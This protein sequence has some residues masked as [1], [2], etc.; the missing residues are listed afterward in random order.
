MQTIYPRYTNTNISD[1]PGVWLAL[2][3]AQNQ[4]TQVQELWEQGETE[5]AQVLLDLVKE[6]LVKAQ[7]KVRSGRWAFPLSV[8]LVELQ[9]DEAK[10][11]LDMAAAELA[12][13]ELELDKAIIVAPFDGIVSD[14]II[15]EGQQ[16]SAMNYVNPGISLVDPSEIKMNGVIDEVD[17]SKVE[18][19]QEAIIT[20]DAFPDK[21][22]NGRVSFI[23]QAGTVKA[24]V[25]SYK[26]TITLQN[27][28]KELRDGMSA[29]ADIVLKR[30]EDALLIPNRAI[31]GSFENPW[32][33]VVVGEQTEER[34]I[35]ISL[36]DGINTE[37]L[38]GLEEGEKV[39]LP[40]VSQI[41][42]FMG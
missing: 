18:V 6:N 13:A 38:S 21:E 1:L 4:V 16:L 32:V 36:S 42:F 22:V 27:P 12:R 33:E 2:E 17:I 11:A 41:P 39:V 35:T 34:E 19:G 25:V 8:K 23:S 20:L 24:G 37:V 7:R 9:V 40:P 14:V 31:Q 3:E 29:T 10:A 28:D 5:G 30:H 26:T 15:K